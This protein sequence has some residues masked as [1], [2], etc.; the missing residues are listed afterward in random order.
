MPPRTWNLT[1]SE[2]RSAEENATY[3]DCDAFMADHAV[4]RN[5]IVATRN[6]LNELF[7]EYVK[8]RDEPFLGTVWEGESYEE[9]RE[10]FFK[11]NGRLFGIGCFRAS[12]SLFSQDLFDQRYTME[13]NSSSPI[14]FHW[15]DVS[16]AH[17][18][19]PAE[20]KAVVDA[21]LKSGDEKD[22]CDRDRR[23]ELH[24]ACFSGDCEAMAVFLNRGCTIGA[25]CKKG[26]SA[27]HYAALSGDCA[28]LVKL[29]A[30]MHFNE[31]VCPLT[32]EDNQGFTAF[33]YTVI[34]NNFD[35]LR[36]ILARSITEIASMSSW[37]T[38]RE[39]LN[40]TSAGMSPFFLCIL[41]ATDLKFIRVWTQGACADFFTTDQSGRTIF[42][43]LATNA[44]L[45]PDATIHL[46]LEGCDENLKTINK[47]IEED[48]IALRFTKLKALLHQQDGEGLNAFH[49]AALSNNRRALLAFL[50]FSETPSDW[51]MEHW[52]GNVAPCVAAT[53]L[54][55]TEDMIRETENY[56][57]VMDKGAVF[58]SP[59]VLAAR[60]GC[61]IT[62]FLDS[63]RPLLCELLAMEHPEEDVLDTLLQLSVRET[64]VDDGWT[65]F[66]SAMVH[67]KYDIARFLLD[68]GYSIRSVDHEKNNFLH[69]VPHTNAVVDVE[70]IVEILNDYNG[71]SL[72]NDRNSS[73][74]LP[75]TEHVHGGNFD[76]VQVLFKMMDESCLYETSVCHN[77]GL[78]MKLTLLDYAAYS[79]SVRLVEFFVE[80][81][82]RATD[83]TTMLASDY[84]HLQVMTYL[85]EKGLLSPLALHFA[86]SLS[87]EDTSLPIIHY[88]LYHG[89][90]PMAK[91]PAASSDSPELN[92]WYFKKNGGTS[93]IEIARE[94]DNFKVFMELVEDEKNRVQQVLVHNGVVFSS[95]RMN[96]EFAGGVRLTRRICDILT[97]PLRYLFEQDEGRIVCCS[98]FVSIA[99]CEQVLSKF[100][101]NAVGN[102]AIVLRFV[103]VASYTAGWSHY[104]DD[105][106]RLRNGAALTILL[107]RLALEVCEERGQINRI[108]R[109]I[110]R[111]V[112]TAYHRSK[113]VPP[114]PLREL[115]RDNCPKVYTAGGGG[116]NVSKDV[117]PRPLSG[118]RGE[119]LRCLYSKL[120]RQAYPDGERIPFAEFLFIDRAGT[121][122]LYDR[123]PPSLSAAYVGNLDDLKE[124]DDLLKVGESNETPLHFAPLSLK[125]TAARSPNKA[126]VLDFY[127][128]RHREAVKD[129]EICSSMDKGTRGALLEV[130]F[131]F[132][133]HPDETSCPNLCA[134][135]I[136]TSSMATMYTLKIYLSEKLNMGEEDSFEISLPT[137]GSNKSVVLSDKTTL[138][139]VADRWGEGEIVLH[140]R[141]TEK[142][143][144]VRVA[145]TFASPAEI[146]SYLLEQNVP[147]D[148]PL[149]DGRRGWTPLFYGVYEG[150]GP[151]VKLLLDA[152]ASVKHRVA[153]ETALFYARRKGPMKLLIEH[154]VDLDYVNDTGL[155]AAGS[156]VKGF[157]RA[158]SEPV[159][160]THPCE[161][162]R[163]VHPTKEALAYLLMHDKTNILT[164]CV[165]EL[166]DREDSTGFVAFTFLDA[167]GVFDRYEEALDREREK[168]LIREAEEKERR[169]ELK[170]RELERQRHR[171]EES[172]LLEKNVEEAR[173]A[174]K[175][176]ALLRRAAIE[177]EA[178]KS[179][180]RTL[181]K[182][183]NILKR[184]GFVYENNGEP[185][186]TISYLDAKD[187]AEAALWRGKN[188]K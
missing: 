61:I 76:M 66:M 46:L 182:M 171:D 49:Y 100:Y 68:H 177:Q 180:S 187:R 43:A 15:K 97:K 11:A 121:G 104:K 37:E 168:E 113:K 146:V 7:L 157:L 80:R 84:G 170:R 130:N 58:E 126:G 181:A 51:A 20:S 71:L 176:E 155:T 101:Y 94:K 86:A 57:C 169:E 91:L 53:V 149:L 83:R 78:T 156:H 18:P 90:D 56:R 3:K 81:G 137:N 24:H 188:K 159:K 22:V 30:D 165:N 164:S 23:T 148:M 45:D 179:V 140:Y 166:L 69:L 33:H 167:E 93:P 145:E 87:L 175:L 139:T 163:Y 173:Q 74:R 10:T 60:M 54:A 120:L 107:S 44:S 88:L 48:P 21:V 59:L 151:V 110:L 138:K 62:P 172:K 63:P 132:Q 28:C 96:Y 125:Q 25:V 6:L 16:T 14:S 150:T 131:R 5:T 128:D 27:V 152:G 9:A 102:C 31:R 41:K 129:V 185:K 178:R 112:A 143:E 136:R 118:R 160:W 89:F 153:N 55:T 38:M 67:G 111:L 82:L 127:T 108:V 19:A 50:S 2:G 122:Q 133:R 124:C 135:Y 73:S 117:S 109:L 72:I 95:V 65:A 12:Y 17:L 32:A 105:L 8:K 147:V 144:H 98:T 116:V 36:H 158:L 42:H 103:A 106:S 39:C 1:P 114:F 34:G 64:A 4:R 92:S 134:E 142:T 154:G 184:H 13:L 77:E 183:S 99:L 85:Q 115:I 52:H 35:A 161:S 162:P 186:N 174:R 123:F 29:I 26:L 75:I 47:E 70:A 79:G 40:S 119:Y 141:L